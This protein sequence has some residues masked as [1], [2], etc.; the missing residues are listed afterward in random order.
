MPHFSGKK[1]YRREIFSRQVDEIRNLLHVL[2][3]REGLDE[4]ENRPRMDMYETG[5]EIVLE[6]DLPGFRLEDIRLKVNGITLVLDAFKPREQAEGCFVCMERSFGSFRYVVQIPA[7]SNPCSIS[8]EY[9]M[10][11]LRVTC[12]KTDGIQIPIKEIEP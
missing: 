12:P 7:N 9:R 6:F 4:A 5:E 11:V 1:P 8:A 10:G 3:M 2:E